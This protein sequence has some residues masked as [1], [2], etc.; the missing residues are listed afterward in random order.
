MNLLRNCVEDGLFSRRRPIRFGA[1]CLQQRRS[2]MRGTIVNLVALTVMAFACELVLV[3]AAAQFLPAVDIESGYAASDESLPPLGG[4]GPESEFLFELTAE[5]IIDAAVH[6]RG[7]DIDVN[8]LLDQMSRPFDA[9]KFGDI[10]MEVGPVRAILIVHRA[11]ELGLQRV[12]RDELIDE[13]N[14]LIDDESDAWF[15]EQ[16]PNGVADDDPFWGDGDVLEFE[17]PDE[18]EG[19][20][21]SSFCGSM[22]ST[23][24]K[25]SSNNK[26]RIKS[27][28]MV[29]HSGLYRYA[30]SR[31]RTYKKVIVWVRT[32]VDEIKIRQDGEYYNGSSWVEYD[33]T[34][35]ASNSSNLYCDRNMYEYGAFRFRSKVTA[36]KTSKFTTFSATSCKEVACCSP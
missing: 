16:Y 21:L 25:K 31:G 11:W 5:E 20:P 2:Q 32:K 18:G 33:K 23:K 24:K 1:K 8:A 36:K 17:V 26:W 6:Y 7:E 27:E 28:S 34:C 9:S 3:Q 22:K 15:D 29:H 13:V 14:V 12:E 35:T 30:R 4:G 19:S 10:E